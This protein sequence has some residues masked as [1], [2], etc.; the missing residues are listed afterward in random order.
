MLFIQGARVT[1]PPRH[2]G[3]VTGYG[4]KIPTEKELL[5][6]GKWRRVYVRNFGN[7]GGTPYVIVNG[8]E[9]KTE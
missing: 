9:V 2:R 1:E 7:G 8:K 3:H 6:K 4:H 5:Y